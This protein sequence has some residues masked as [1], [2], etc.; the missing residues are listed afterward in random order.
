MLQSQSIYWKEKQAA[1]A[2]DNE[3]LFTYGDYE[4]KTS[5]YVF[6][7]KYPYKLVFGWL[8]KTD[9]I[10]LQNSIRGKFDHKFNVTKTDTVYIYVKTHDECLRIL[11]AVPVTPL[12]IYAPVTKETQAVEP[13]KTATYDI[14]ILNRH[15]PFFKHYDAWVDFQYNARVPWRHKFQKYLGESLETTRLRSHRYEFNPDGPND[16]FQSVY[17]DFAEFEAQYPVMMIVNPDIM[18]SIVRCTVYKCAS[19]DK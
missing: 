13:Y 11:R 7:H 18:S 6:Y 15:K 10:A 8:N 12:D 17:V 2:L 14:K 5:P 4:I 16:K 3:P 1:I 19:T 9:K